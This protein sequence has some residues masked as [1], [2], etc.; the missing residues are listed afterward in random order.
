MGDRRV[1]N[2]VS[3]MLAY[4]DAGIALHASLDYK[5]TLQQVAKLILRHGFGEL[6][7]ID[8]LVPDG[9]IE[10]L[11]ITHA[12]PGMADSCARLAAMPLEREHLL[13]ASALATRTPQVIDITD[14]LTTSLA[15]DADHLAALREL[16]L[17]SAIVVPL[18]TPARLLG[19]LV[20]ASRE[21]GRYTEG[22][23]EIT[24]EVARRA[25]CA[26]ENAQ[27]Y[28]TARRASD[29]RDEVLGIVAHD[30]R[31]PLDGIR[32][33]LELIARRPSV[34]ADPIALAAL[35]IA[36]ASIARANRLMEDLLDI[37]RIEAG[38]LSIDSTVA[39]VDPII[40]EAVRS[41]QFAANAASHE[42]VH[43]GVA[44][45]MPAVRIDGDRIL[46]VLGNLIS[47]AIKFS[48]PG[49][50]ILVDAVPEL[51]NVVVSV[52]DTGPGI[53][54][55]NLTR[56][57]TRFWR[58]G[59]A[60]RDSAGLGLAICKGIIEA[61]GGRIWAESEPGSG[62]S[63]RFSLPIAERSASMPAAGA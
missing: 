20:I 29:A 14:D 36:T 41:N 6:C 57:F 53:A 40:D 47:N 24:S 34:A 19:V 63:F 7:I 52:R 46:Q 3:A 56:V 8:M 27:R 38:T 58:S 9:A 4:W 16:A 22:D 33:A 10:R 43:V 17:R 45:A 42:L 49:G 31:S 59:A 37:R 54:A 62:S 48:P 50:R 1:G 5:Q 30:V 25:A 21:P 32:L 13:A 55:E 60:R 15:R 61:H 11:T 2:G 44:A 51:D 26:I 18:V 23:L 39:L 12:D 35:D 28:E